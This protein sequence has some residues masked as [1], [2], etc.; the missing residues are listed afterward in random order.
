[1]YNSG[2][3]K[4]FGW[5]IAVATLVYFLCVWVTPEK[6]INLH[7]QKYTVVSLG[8]CID[9][10]CSFSYKDMDGNDGF[11]KSYNPVVVGEKV[12]RECWNKLNSENLWCEANFDPVK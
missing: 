12:Q 1:M 6:K 7:T 11:G 4:A 3:F 8:Q 9:G 2:L 10:K 5:S